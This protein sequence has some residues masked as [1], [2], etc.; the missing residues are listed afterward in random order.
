MADRE[1]FILLLFF[2]DAVYHPINMRLVAVKQMP[3]LVLLSYYLAAVRPLF[4][5]EDG[6]FDPQIPFLGSVRILSV[7][8]PVKTRKVALSMGCGVNDVCHASLQT[9]RKIPAL[10]AFFLLSHPPDPD[11]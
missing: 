5:T 6:G 9:R 1:Y 7:D 10:A 4:Q 2:Q 8:L 3:E 11:G